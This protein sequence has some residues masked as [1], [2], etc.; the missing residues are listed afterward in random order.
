[1]MVFN[2]KGIS[3]IQIDRNWCDI[4]ENVRLADNGDNIEIVMKETSLKF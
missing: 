3:E 4:A 2:V 1:M